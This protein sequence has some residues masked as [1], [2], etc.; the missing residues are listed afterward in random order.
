MSLLCQSKL[1]VGLICGIILC[2]GS[3]SAG[4][5]TL[6]IPP[7]GQAPADYAE[8]ARGLSPT[9]CGVCHHKQFREWSSS[10]HAG[11]ARGGVLGQLPAFD[12]ETRIACLNCHAPTSEQQAGFLAAEAGAVPSLSGVDCVACHVRRHR[13]HGPTHKSIT[14]HG[15][16]EARPLFKDA[17]FCS[18]CHQFPDWGERVKGK[19]LEN[20]ERE[21]RASPYARAGIG[22]R[23]CHMPD[24][25]HEFKGIHD[26]GMS[27]KALE[28]KV[29]RRREGIEIRLRNVGAGHVLPTYATPRIRV[30]LH[31][32]DPPGEDPVHS[33]QRQLRRH[34]DLGWTEPADTRL[35]PDQEVRLTRALEPGE[36]AVVTVLVEPDA[37]YHEQVYPNLLEA[38]GEELEPVSLRMLRAAQRRTGQ[39]GFPLYRAHCPPWTG[40]ETA[41]ALD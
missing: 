18:P 6:P 8:P 11:A 41:C 36:D 2:A 27:R 1:G 3:V 35:R 14:P 5:W 31:R 22:C 32:G 15:P 13:R 30:V 4:Y 17:A 10:L 24:G 26:P 16:V 19:L 20:T 29:R 33:I 7:Q 23:D 38:I 39:T 34:P 21:W 28:V 12:R 9:A 40:R 25:S 37:F